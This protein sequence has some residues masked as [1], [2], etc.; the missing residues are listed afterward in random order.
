MPVCKKSANKLDVYYSL[1]LLKQQ[2]KQEAYWATL[3]QREQSIANRFKRP[4]LTERYVFAHGL[5]RENVAQYVEESAAELEF[6]VTD[7][8]KPF[9]TKYPELSFNMSH[10]ENAWALA[11]VQTRC[12]L[13]VD[14]EYFKQRDSWAGLVKKCFAVEEADYWL[15]LNAEQQGRFFYQLWVRKEAFVKAVGQGI[16]LGLDS[17]V[18]NPKAINQ[19]LRVPKNYALAEDWEVY[20]LNLADDLLAAVVCNQAKL[21]LNLIVVT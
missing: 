11:V 17:C 20:P 9:L 10:T 15:A 16:T 6:S 2:E 12:Q 3:D 19:F 13:G 5:L 18:F 14:I 1:D 7:R 21:S 4:I 8:G